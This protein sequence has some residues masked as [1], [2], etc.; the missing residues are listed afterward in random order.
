MSEWCTDCTNKVL[1]LEESSRTYRE[2]CKCAFPICGCFFP[3]ALLLC[4]GIMFGIRQGDIPLGINFMGF[5]IC[6]G[7]VLICLPWYFCGCRNAIYD[8]SRAWSTTSQFPDN[9]MANGFITRNMY[10]HVP[11]TLIQEMQ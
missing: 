9:D 8:V 4:F 5:I 7:L 1:C 3:L 6:I 2:W 10:E 11:L